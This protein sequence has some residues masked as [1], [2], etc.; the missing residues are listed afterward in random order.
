MSADNLMLIHR[1]DGKFY[2]VMEFASQDRYETL[3]ECIG[4][5]AT[6]DTEYDALVYASSEYTEYGIELG[7]GWT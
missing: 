1:R 2:V 6:F 4:R 7:E 3:D 5:A